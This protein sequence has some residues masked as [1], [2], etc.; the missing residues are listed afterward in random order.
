MNL[1]APLAVSVLLAFI[2]AC[3]ASAAE[4]V[5]ETLISVE[6][7]IRKGNWEYKGE[8]EQGTEFSIIK[9]VLHGGKQ[10]G[11]DV[12]TIDN[13]RLNGWSELEAEAEE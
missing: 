10:E 6:E 2:T 12:V 9:S 8:T 13:G 5:S 11:V 1:F 3:S 7:N 4:S